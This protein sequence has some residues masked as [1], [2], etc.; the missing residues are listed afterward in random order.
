MTTPCTLEFAP[1]SSTGT[2]GG[3][4]SEHSPWSPE[5]SLLRTGTRET[6]EIRY[7]DRDPDALVAVGAAV[8][9]VGAFRC[10]FR[11]TAWFDDDVLWLDPDPAQPFRDLTDALWSA[12]PDRPLYGGA[13]DTVVP[14]LTVGER[15]LGDRTALERAEREIAASLPVRTYVDRVLLI[16]GAQV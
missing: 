1:M 3:P 11:R 16:A 2:T 7:A 14:H 9:T 8:G 15:R 6:I 13:H 5:R 4:T 10:S 12:F